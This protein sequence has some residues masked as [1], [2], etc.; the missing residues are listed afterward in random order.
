MAYRTHDDAYPPAVSTDTLVAPYPSRNQP[1]S[2]DPMDAP[3]GEKPLP[4]AYGFTPAQSRDELAGGF[5]AQQQYP[6]PYARAPPPKKSRKGLI[7]L[8]AG[9]VIVVIIAIVLI[10]YFVAV[11]PHSGDKSSS[12]GGKAVHDNKLIVGRD[13]TN[14]TTETGATFTYKNK[15]GGY[16]IH[17]PLNPYNDGAKAQSYTPALNESWKFGV[18][19]ILGVNLGGWLVPEPFIVPGLY[20]KYFDDQNVNGDEWTLSI[21]MTNDTAGGGLAQMEE[22]YRTFITEEDF[23]AIAGAG[24]NWIRLPV[25]FNAFGT[26]GNE[27]FLPHA[28]WNYTLKAFDWARKYGIRINLDLHTMPGSQNG[29]NHSGKKGY[30]AWMSSVMG[31]ANT[32]RSLDFIR[33]VVEFISQPEYKNVVPMISPVNEPQG[34]DQAAMHAF[35]LHLYQMIREITGVGEGNGP[36]IAIHDHFEPISNWQNFLTGADRLVLDTHPYFTFGG[37]DNPSIDSFPPKP[38][39]TWGTQINA[40]MNT[41]GMTIAGEWSLGFNDCGQYIWG[42]RDAP[43]TTNCDA[44][45]NDYTKWTP[46]TKD[47]F[48]SLA[49]SH[50]DALGNFFFWT[51]KVGVSKNTGLVGA[52]M[53]SY[54]LGLEQG[55]IPDD[56]RSAL[57]ECERLGVV[58]QPDQYYVGQ[59]QPWQTGGAG[60]GQLAPTATVGLDWPPAALVTIANSPVPTYTATAPIPT[61]PTQT[62]AAAATATADGWFNDADNLPGIA[63]I[64]GC[65]YP[66]PWNPGDVPPPPC[67]GGQQQAPLARRLAGPQPTAASL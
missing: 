41:F 22:H 34:Q 45:W 59:L 10:V 20:E 11:K 17:D 8:I 37:Q 48:L 53:W 24:L 61:L 44:E 14:V 52:P 67:T 15:F 63:P 56:P 66:D 2:H 3:Y 32:E 36:Y 18:D 1:W 29:L 21:A 39:S 31:Y 13:G 7:A 5:A 51:W 55:W 38:C 46:D 19:R 23:A 64:A 16:F 4:M 62:F 25:P 26:I 9:I 60:A 28:A 12:N 65:A 58:A 43:H 6:N 57:G 47:K 50:M 35:Y 30:V 27:P 42:L 49:K 33:S 54:S 40:S